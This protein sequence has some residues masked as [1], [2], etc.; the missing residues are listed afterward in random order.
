VT[1]Y[2]KSVSPIK[3]VQHGKIVR[4]ADSDEEEDH[5]LPFHV[6]E[7]HS[8]RVWYMLRRVFLGF[9]FNAK[10]RLAKM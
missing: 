5:P 10:D 6:A 4:T 2:K 9:K 8:I 1:V 3:H 7:G